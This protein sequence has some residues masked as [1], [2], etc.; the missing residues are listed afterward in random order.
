M[1]SPIGCVLVQ[2][3]ELGGALPQSALRYLR[4]AVEVCLYPTRRPSGGLNP[5]TLGLKP[6]TLGLPLAGG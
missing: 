2:T 6:S 1:V 4:D 5:S 3:S